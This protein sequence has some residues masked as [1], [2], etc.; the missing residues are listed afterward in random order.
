MTG[1]RRSVT[2]LSRAGGRRRTAR[3]LQNPWRNPSRWRS[4][5]LPNGSRKQR[6]SRYVRTAWELIDSRNN[7]VSAPRQVHEMK[8]NKAFLHHFASQNRAI[9]ARLAQKRALR[10]KN[11]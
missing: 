2:F 7:F 8:Q 10:G 6:L 3:H 4:S 1:R 9:A 5:G 11:I